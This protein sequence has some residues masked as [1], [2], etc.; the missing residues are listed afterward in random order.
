MKP[1]T[2]FIFWPLLVWLMLL[3]SPKSLRAD[4]DENA[5]WSLQFKNASISEALRQI[6]QTTGIK[7]I[8]PSR[9]GNQVITRSYNNQTIEHILKDLFRDMN[10]ALVWSH[11]EKG[12]DSVKILAL[13]KVG[14]SGATHSSDAVRP[15]IRDYSAPKYPAQRR[16]PPKRGLSP[17]TRSIKD[18][19]PEDTDSEVSAEQE[20]EEA[21]QAEPEFKE[22][23]KEQTS[24]SGELDEETPAPLRK[25]PAQS[26]EEEEKGSEEPPSVVGQSE[27]ESGSSSPGEE[28]PTGEQ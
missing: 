27:E 12:I 17:P 10:Y 8:P 3:L 20:R 4:V 28:A 16:A 11:G 18:S 24:S 5:L 2:F 6:T 9:L 21:E 15:N 1:R 7:I 13:D 14:A 23:D 19:E 26:D 25:L 22:E